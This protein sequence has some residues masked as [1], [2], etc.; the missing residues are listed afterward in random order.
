MRHAFNHVLTDRQQYVLTRRYGLDDS[1][2]RTLST[3]GKEMGLSR[4]R[5]RQIEREALHRLREH[6]GIRDPGDIAV[7]LGGDVAGELRSDAGRRALST[8]LDRGPQAGVRVE[9]RPL[10]VVGAPVPAPLPARRVD[11]D[12]ADGHLHARLA[13]FGGSRVG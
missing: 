11:V 12:G 5:V 4:E 2:Y 9:T 3:V 7:D 6:S 1:E 8:D 13:A 10:G